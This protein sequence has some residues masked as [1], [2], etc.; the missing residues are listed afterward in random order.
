MAET[1]K[2]AAATPKR[3]EKEHVYDFG[4]AAV[5]LTHSAINGGGKRSRECSAGT[6]AR[7][8]SG[9]RPLP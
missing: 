8:T 7:L 2:R 1:K 3:G 6:G 9:A 4:N 5:L